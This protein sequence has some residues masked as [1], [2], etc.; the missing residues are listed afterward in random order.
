VR[1]RIVKR[2][3]RVKDRTVTKDILT[4]GVAMLGRVVEVEIDPAYCEPVW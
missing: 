2:D 4:V 1:G 3:R